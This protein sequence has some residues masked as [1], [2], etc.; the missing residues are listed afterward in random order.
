[1]I[2]ALLLFGL[3]GVGFAQFNGSLASSY[4][5]A[6]N[7]TNTSYI[8]SSNKIITLTNN[9]YTE[10][11]TK[12]NATEPNL[13]ETLSAPIRGAWNGMVMMLNA[14]DI[15]QGIFYDLGYV[16]GL[17]DQVINVILA[18]IAIV[19]IFAMIYVLFKVQP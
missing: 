10:I 9:T 12:A 4:G 15:T 6:S 19:I 17:P 3:L 11:N 1:M 8:E 14:V 7:Y 5:L 16:L 2:V 13:I 18:L